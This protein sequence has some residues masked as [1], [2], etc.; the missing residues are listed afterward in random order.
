MEDLCVHYDN[1]VRNAFGDVIQFEFGGDSLDPTYTEGVLDDFFFNLLIKFNI[2][3]F[4]LLL[5][6]LCDI[7]SNNIKYLGDGVPVD[8]KRVY[9]NVTANYPCREEC[10]L[11]SDEILKITDDVLLSDN[12]KLVNNIFIEELR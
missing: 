1:T 5:F 2:S 7:F 4:F 6:K 12:F 11:D 3:I 8:L 9:F 10:T